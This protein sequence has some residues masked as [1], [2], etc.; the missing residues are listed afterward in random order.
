MAACQRD[1]RLRRGGLRRSLATDEEW[2]LHGHTET[3]EDYPW[4]VIWRDVLNHPCTV[5]REGEVQHPEAGARKAQSQRGGSGLFR[6][7]D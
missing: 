5:V 3:L 4:K 2:L 6:L 7:N 1:V